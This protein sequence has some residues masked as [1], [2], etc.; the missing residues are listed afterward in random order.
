VSKIIYSVFFA[1]T[2]G[3][4][5]GCEMNISEPTIDTSTD[6]LMKQTIIE[7]RASLPE[8][9]RVQFDEAITLL[10]FSNG[11]KDIFSSGGAS[12]ADS[13]NKIMEP[14]HGKTGQQLILEAENFK[15]ERK[16]KEREQ[17]VQEIAALEKKREVADAANEDLKNFT[18]ISSKFYQE[19]DVYGSNQPIIELTVRNGTNAPVSRAYF[20]GV[21]ASPQR[22]VPWHTD[23]FNYPISGGLEPE[24]EQSWRLAPNMFSDW[25]SVDAPVDAVFTVTVQRIDG[26][27]GEP[28]YSSTGFTEQDKER[29]SELRAKYGTD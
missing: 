5:T 4:I 2:L 28:L 24:E 15:S 12:T 1:I 14:L 16:E 21:I 7:V 3:L 18:I 9:Q 10:I 22:S 29:L 26:A 19:K 27:D 8:N 6:E 23:T 11:M 17:V 25:G 20:E 13:K